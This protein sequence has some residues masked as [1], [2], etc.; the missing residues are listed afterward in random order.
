MRIVKEY[1]QR[2]RL[3]REARAMSQ[4]DLE[5]RCRVKQGEISKVER[6]EHDPKFRTVIQLCAGLS[7]YL[8]DVLRDISRGNEGW[9]PGDVPV[10][11]AEEVALKEESVSRYI[12]DRVRLVRRAHGLTQGQLA[13][14]VGFSLS[15]VQRIERGA[16]LAHLSRLGLVAEF[17]NVGLDDFL[18]SQHWSAAGRRGAA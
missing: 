1:G 8:A 3:L 4:E 17:F 16:A 2:V 14:C 18:P 13:A 5:D 15:T 10:R 6:G 7:A 11:T 9:D 12:G